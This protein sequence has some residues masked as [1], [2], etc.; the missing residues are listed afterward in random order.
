MNKAILVVLVILVVGGGIAYW[1][2]VSNKNEN[3]T[4]QTNDNNTSK[5][6]DEKR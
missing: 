2:N 6:N 4:L 1:S 5:N 3:P